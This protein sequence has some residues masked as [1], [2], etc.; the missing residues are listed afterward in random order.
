MSETVSETVS[1][2]A[3]KI[4]RGLGRGS[5]HSLCITCANQRAEAVIT[6]AHSK[7]ALI[8]SERA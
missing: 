8:Q 5:A 7:G 4:W 3:T 6:S 1:E 2:L